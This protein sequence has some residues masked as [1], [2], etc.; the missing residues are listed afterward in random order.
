MEM[1]SSK[2]NDRIIIYDKD[3][4]KRVSE[5]NRTMGADAVSI[6][7]T[8][9]ISRKG[10]GLTM[11]YGGG[12][13][14]GTL[15]HDNN[16]TAM[17]GTIQFSDKIAPFPGTLRAYGFVN[18]DKETSSSWQVAIFA[19]V[20]IILSSGMVFIVL[21][22]IRERCAERQRLEAFK[23][24]IAKTTKM[25][26]KN[27]QVTPEDYE[28]DFD[29]DANSYIELYNREKVIASSKNCLRLSQ[30]EPAE[31]KNRKKSG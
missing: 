6:V 20:G 10:E 25:M 27:I 24:T 28:N 12:W 14:N 13:K 18:H 9:A 3:S 16:M 19:V 31:K 7:H 29:D 1:N 8:V 17:I 26:D 23:S 15:H 4:G 11:V 5:W 2:G 22:F 30:S 21:V